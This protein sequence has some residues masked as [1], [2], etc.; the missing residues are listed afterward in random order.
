MDKII[1]LGIP[2]IGEQI[3][4]GLDSEDLVQCLEVSQTWRALA[5]TT[6]LSKWKGKILEACRTGKTK[7]VKLLLENYNS[8]ENGVNATD[9]FGSTALMEACLNGHTDVV[10][11]LLDNAKAQRRH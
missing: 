4:K 9:G 10:K 5:E 2:H 8:E 7:I 6:L 1:N 3:F 11:L